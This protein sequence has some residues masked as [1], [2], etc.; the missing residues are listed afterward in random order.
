MKRPIVL[1]AGVALSVLLVWFFSSEAGRAMLNPSSVHASASTDPSASNVSSHSN[2]SP[3][4]RP[5]PPLEISD[6]ARD[7]NSPATDIRADLKILGTIIDT[8]RSNARANP[9]G[10][11]AEITAILTGKNTFRLALIPPAHPAINAQGELCD[12]WGRPFFF[13]QV[14]GTNME[15]RSAGPD[16]KMWTDDDA[17]FVP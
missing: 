12:R 2:A 16:R 8:F 14:S 7:L 13:H 6:L 17:L 3:S 9:T 4:T 5:L 15:I 1:V 10:N 11:N